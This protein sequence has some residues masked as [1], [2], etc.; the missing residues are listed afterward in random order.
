[1]DKSPKNSEMDIDTKS[2]IEKNSLQVSPILP[3]SPLIHNRYNLERPKALN[4]KILKQTRR[5]FD[6]HDFEYS[7]SGGTFRERIIYD[8]VQPPVNEKLK[9]PIHERKHI[10]CQTLIDLNS[11]KKINNQI[12]HNNEIDYS[13]FE[14][15]ETNIS[16]AM[17]TKSMVL[18][19]PKP[20]QEGENFCVK[21]VIC[22]YDENKYNHT[23]F[24]L[25]YFNILRKSNPS[26]LIEK[27]CEEDKMCYPESKEYPN[28]D[29]IMINKANYKK[30]KVKKTKR[31]ITCSCKNSHC[32]KFYCE[33]FRKNGYCGSYCKC[34]NCK[35]QE[36]NKNIDTMVKSINQNKQ[37]KFAFKISKANNESTIDIKG[38]NCTCKRSRC[39]KRSSKYDEKHLNCSSEYHC[40]KN[41]AYAYKLN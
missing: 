35:N 5:I 31:K 24:H 41:S 8:Q 20:N 30:H 15:V 18:I 17:N 6:M 13:K 38:S 21:D 26:E 34:K 11:D 7:M 16:T 28:S 36:T 9:T 10:N 40:T 23:T 39:R 27:I 32:I 3:I 4:K 22:I 29:I 2:V 25:N 1:M 37:E 12:S 33:C 14:S 19:K